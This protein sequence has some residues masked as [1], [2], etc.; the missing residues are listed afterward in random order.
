MS[1]LRF[2]AL[3]LLAL[4]IGGLAVLGGVG[5]P[6]IFS[7]LEAHDPTAGRT[8]AGLVFGAVFDRFQHVAWIVGALLLIVLGVRAALGPRPRRLAW[9]VWTVV[10]M[11]AMSVVTSLV[12]APRIDRIRESVTGTV[13][14][15]P[16]T[17][18]RKVEF[19]R[20][21]G[22]STGL[23]LVT[24]LAGLGLMWAEVR[25]GR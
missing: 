9:R 7:V 18:A 22:A 16:D 19:G 15:L 8:L 13:A 25:D 1:L 21:H 23:M 12:L 2:A 6:V 4:W 5:A 10:A 11:L 3:V 17:D 24:L 20:L 14:A